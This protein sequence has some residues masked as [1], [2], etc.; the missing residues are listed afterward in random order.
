MPN[1]LR[2]LDSGDIE[3]IVSMAN[4]PAIADDM[5]TLPSPFLEQHALEL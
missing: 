1:I 3:K 4:N 5:S 2:K